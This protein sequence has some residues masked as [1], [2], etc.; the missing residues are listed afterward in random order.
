MLDF[1][2]P[3]FKVTAGILELLSGLFEH[4]GRT[5]HPDYL[6]RM[7]IH[8]LQQITRPAAQVHPDPMGPRIFEN[9]PVQIKIAQD[10]ALEKVPSGAILSKNRRVLSLRSLIIRS[11]SLMSSS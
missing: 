11:A 9:R 5:V 8:G 10:L 6:F 2:E 3:D 4:S 1:T 7:P